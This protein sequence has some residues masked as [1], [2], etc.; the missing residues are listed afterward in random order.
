[1]STKKKDND[2]SESAAAEAVEAMEASEEFTCAIGERSVSF[3]LDESLYVRDCIFGAAYLFIDRCFILLSRP[4][5]GLLGVRLKARTDTSEAEL[6]TLA[7][8]FVNELL[9]QVVRH[10]V[11]ESTARI[12]EFYMARAFFAS[13]SRST[14]DDLLAEL[15]DE[16]MEEAPLEISVPWEE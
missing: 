14:I 7:G 11:G 5:E 16:E 15:D 10:Q 2:K 9:N 3:A 6:E 12:R 13:D 1:M 8:E 4:A